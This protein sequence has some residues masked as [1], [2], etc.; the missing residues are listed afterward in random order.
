MIYTSQES[1]YKADT[2]NTNLKQCSWPQLLREMP[3]YM[4]ISNFTV[5]KLTPHT[6]DEYISCSCFK[7]ET[8]PQ[9]NE[10]EK[11]V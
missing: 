3:E 4:R 9:P 7:V 1:S 6:H 5:L 8:I 10:I 11:H 2:I